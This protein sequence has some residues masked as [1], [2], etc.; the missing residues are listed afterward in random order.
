METEKIVTACVAPTTKLIDA[1]TAA[2]G[3]AY[4]PRYV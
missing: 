3:K 1:V 4:E 2:I